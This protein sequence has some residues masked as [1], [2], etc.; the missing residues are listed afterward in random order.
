MVPRGQGTDPDGALLQAVHTAERRNE[1]H[2]KQV[3]VAV[4]SKLLNRH[5]LDAVRKSNV[6]TTSNHNSCSTDQSV[7]EWFNHRDRASE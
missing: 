4:M 5:P 6:N 1:R 3:I 2:V 7:H